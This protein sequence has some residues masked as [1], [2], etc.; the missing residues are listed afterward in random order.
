MISQK[1]FYLTDIKKENQKVLN[2]RKFY[3]C[4]ICLVVSENL[5]SQLDFFLA[6]G[7]I[8][9]YAIYKII[10][11]KKKITINFLKLFLC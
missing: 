4:F 11:T 8:N 2:K 5:T 10:L 6:M 1:S 9:G 7:L 3:V